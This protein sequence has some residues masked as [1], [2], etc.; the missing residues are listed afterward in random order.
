M[1]RGSSPAGPT[2][3][4]SSWW[5]E[6]RRPR[7]DSRRV[8]RGDCLLLLSQMADESGLN[9]SDRR[10]LRRVPRTTCC[11]GRGAT[12]GTE[13]TA[14]VTLRRPS[15][16]LVAAPPGQKT[17]RATRAIDEEDYELATVRGFLTLFASVGTARQFYN[18]FIVP[19]GVPAEI[20]LSAVRWTQNSAG[21]QGR[22]SVWVRY[23]SRFGWEGVKPID[24]VRMPDGGLTTV[25]NTRAA[26]WFRLG[27]GQAPGRIHNASDPLPESMVRL[28]RFGSARTWGEAVVQRTASQ[29]PKPLPPY[30]SPVPPKLRGASEAGL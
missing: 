5:T 14:P 2:R 22:T 1:S 20:N 30:G 27:N 23:L 25:D 9:P 29:T 15:E 4:R 13:P 10:M 16:P 6:R 28:G 8:P 17:V 12:R 3:T 7:H 21:G 11:P 18:Q 24:V 19:S 26:T